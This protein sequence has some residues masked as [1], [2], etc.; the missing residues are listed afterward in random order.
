MFTKK[1][2]KTQRRFTQKKRT[3]EIRRK[4]DQKGTFDD[5]ISERPEKLCD[6]CEHWRCDCD[7]VIPP[8]NNS[9]ECSDDE[10]YPSAINEKGEKGIVFGHW[11]IPDWVRDKLTIVFV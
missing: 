11:F 5:D 1:Q 4:R 9:R 3:V 7:R 6:D 8:A 10:E 2:I